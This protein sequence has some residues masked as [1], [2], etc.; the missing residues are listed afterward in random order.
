MPTALYT[1]DTVREFDRRAIEEQGI[2]GY[3]LM[4]RA[5][6]RL[7]ATING[8]FGDAKRLLILCGS[9]NNAGDGYVLARMLRA[10]QRD[11]CVIALSD[12]ARLTGDAALAYATFRE[13]GGVTVDWRPD[14]LDGID[15]V[16]DAII[17]TGLSRPLGGP[18]KKIV[19]ALN[20]ADVPVLSVDVPTGLD[21]DSGHVL[22][23]AVRAGATV[24]FIGLKLGLFDGQGPEHTGDLIFDDLGVSIAGGERLA[25]V[26]RLIDRA[27][28]A[29]AL[30][31][32]KFDTHKGLLG[33]VLVIGGGPGM[34]GAARLAGEAAL[35]AGAG[36]VTVATSPTNVAAIVSGRPELMVAGIEDPSDI[37]SLLGNVDVVA[38]GPG[39]GLDGW[40]QGLLRIVD[41]SRLPI[42]FDADA[43][44]LLAQQPRARDDAIL[45]PHPGEAAR[46]LSC[47]VADIQRDRR[48][49]VRALCRQYGGVVVLKG[50]RTLVA[51][52]D[53]LPW[54]CAHGNPGMATAGMGDVLTGV[55]AGLLG[56]MRDPLPAACCGVLAHALAGDLAAQNGQRGLIAGDLS[57][58][59]PK[60]LNP[61]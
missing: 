56:Q 2:P 43:L 24:T 42:V 29:Q 35:R 59:L 48:A 52:R 39:L 7:L 4:V 46:L 47:S 30:P 14:S 21:A 38:I 20:R 31:P 22:G 54:L 10:Q 61:S 23:D 44:T 5:G 8:R 51:R 17:G 27:S 50:A 34:A 55:I 18:A 19:S 49:A 33:H 41:A 32:R 45:T 12:P 37:G 1:A 15:L 6:Q 36:R 58:R 40:A 16:V 26:A 11:L 25:P 13:A 57:R 28:F 53:E 3:T 60:V 9:G